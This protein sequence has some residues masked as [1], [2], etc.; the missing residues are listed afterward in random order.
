MENRFHADPVD[1]VTCFSKPKPPAKS[2]PPSELLPCASLEGVVDRLPHNLQARAHLNHKATGPVQV[3]FAGVA[4]P[5]DERDAAEHATLADVHA[6]HYFRARDVVG[7]TEGL[8]ALCRLLPPSVHA[9]P[10]RYR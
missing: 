9:D 2:V 8:I 7:A 4:E 3:N 5:L 1:P 10:R 6:C